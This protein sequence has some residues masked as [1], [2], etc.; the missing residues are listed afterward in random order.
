[1][2]PNIL[3]IVSIAALVLIAL[4]ICVFKIKDKPMKVAILDTGINNASV[5]SKLISKEFIN[6]SSKDNNH[7]ND[8]AQII[9]SQNKTIIYDAKV[10]NKDGVGK[11]EDTVEAIDW[12]IKNNVKIINMSY[13]F[14]HYYQTL[15]KKIIEARQ[16]DIIIIC[17]NGNDIF[18]QKEYP[19]SYQETISIGVMKNEKSKSIFN[20][21]DNAD[22][23]IS[24]NNHSE[25]MIN[26]TSEATALATNRL[27]KKYK[28]DFSNMDKQELITLIKEE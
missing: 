24:L 1:M 2:K 10:L 26:N 15:Y 16:H 14:T 20:S 11:V 27:I 5:E 22:L 6:D 12:A 23:Y 13:G 17:A 4:M 21:N 19:A 18:G 9:E 28:S 25:K 3:K 7:A 8:I